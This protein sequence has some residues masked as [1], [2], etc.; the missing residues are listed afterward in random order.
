MKDMKDIFEDI[1]PRDAQVN[2]ITHAI[3]KSI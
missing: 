1:N 3:G 2:K